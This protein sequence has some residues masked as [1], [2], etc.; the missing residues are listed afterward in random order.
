MQSQSDQERLVKE[1]IVSDG[2]Q[3]M[4]REP[5]GSQA[6]YF[7]QCARLFEQMGRSRN[8]RNFLFATQQFIGL[9]VKVDNQMV[10]AADDQKHGRMDAGKGISGKIRPAAARDDCF[11]AR[12]PGQKQR[13]GRKRFPCLRRSN[14][15]T[16][17]RS[18]AGFG[19]KASLT[20]GDR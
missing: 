15:G 6:G 17:R 12:F 14:P 16:A 8:N 7:V 1:H 4:T 18:E 13:E 19:A 5:L 3:K 10:Q 11:Y 20:S 2:P 9:P